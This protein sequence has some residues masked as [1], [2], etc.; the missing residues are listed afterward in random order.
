MYSTLWILC[1][2]RHFFPS[3]IISG[4]LR[5]NILL[6]SFL[7]LPLSPF[8]LLHCPFITI[9][10]HGHPFS[11]V[12]IHIPWKKP[13]LGYYFPL[14]EKSFKVLGGSTI[15]G[16]SMSIYNH[17]WNISKISVFLHVPGHI[18]NKNMQKQNW[19]QKIVTAG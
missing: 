13:T 2:A 8:R 17:C 18:Q 15:D 4:Y 19:N 1:P 7:S 12:P 16:W 10:T 3:R 11:N 5:D 9:H 6:S 14:V